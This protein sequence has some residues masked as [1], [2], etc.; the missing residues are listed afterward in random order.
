[1]RWILCTTWALWL[2]AQAPAQ[3]AG[4]IMATGNG[5]PRHELLAPGQVTT[6]F[7][8]G[9][10]VADA[11]AAGV[12]LPVTLSGLSV[13]VSS[14]IPGY[15]QR[16]PI[17]SIRSFGGCGSTVCDLTF[18]T[19]QIPIEATCVPTTGFPNECTMAGSPA[20]QLTVEHNGRRGPSYTVVVGGMKPHFLNSCDTV[21][22]TFGGLCYS[23]VT[24]SDGKPVTGVNPA[25]AGETIVAYAT[26]LG[27]PSVAVK[28]GEAA[29]R[30]APLVIPPPL[31]L[32]YKAVSLQSPSPG[33]IWIPSRDWITPSYAGLAVGAVGLYQLNVKMPDELPVGVPT[34]GATGLVMTGNVRLS[35]GLGYF[36]ETAGSDYVDFCL[37]P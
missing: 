4:Q 5:P 36:G 27:R 2:A 1:M 17:F 26:G 31:L 7:V 30:E 3:T 18:V 15:P 9:L 22:G 28:T 33:Q 29:T 16:L 37:A 34:C 13:L 21:F 11:T 8:Y 25:R 19:V 35:I 24:H 10:T 6:L 23:F 12:P 32:S 20:I 14:S